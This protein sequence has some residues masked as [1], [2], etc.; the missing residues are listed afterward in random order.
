MTEREIKIGSV[1]RFTGTDCDVPFSRVL[2]I[3]PRMAGGPLA[4]RFEDGR[5]DGGPWERNLGGWMA[6]ETFVKH[7]EHVSDPPEPARAAPPPAARPIIPRLQPDRLEYL[8]RL[9]STTQFPI[10]NPSVRELL[11]EIAA[12]EQELATTQKI[13][14]STMPADRE[15]ITQLAIDRDKAKAQADLWELRAYRLGWDRD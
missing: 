12:L 13:V 15:Y 4:V 11:L 14:T 5:T 2:S 9:V 10:H 8:R 6:P 7:H 3:G 1:W